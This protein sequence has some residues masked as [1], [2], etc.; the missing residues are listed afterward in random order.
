M[1]AGCRVQYLKPGY[2]EYETGVT[3]TKYKFRQY[4][5]RIA[6]PMRKH[7]YAGGTDVELQTITRKWR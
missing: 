3:I 2:P 1:T 6:A 5:K 4:I 7:H